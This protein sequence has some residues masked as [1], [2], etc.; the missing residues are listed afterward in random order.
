[1][2]GRNLVA[3]TDEKEK[4][5]QILKE[6]FFDGIDDDNMGIW[7]HD[8]LQKRLPGVEK[9][10]A[11]DYGTEDGEI[12]DENLP[13]TLVEMFG[14]ELF[15]GAFGADLRGK[16]LDKFFELE[17]YSKIFK[18]F[19]GSSNYS[20][21]T[22]KEMKVKFSNDT[23]E[24]SRKYLQSLKDERQKH[25][26]KPGGVFARRFVEQIRL[27]DIFAGIRSEPKSGR[28]E[29]AVP[30][31]DLK[32]LRNFQENMKNQVLEILNGSEENRAIVTLPTGAGKTRI[33]VEAIVKFLND[34]SVDRNILWIAQSQ[35]VCEQAVLCFKQIWEQHGKGETL[36][37]YRAW[38]VND[39]PTSDERGIIVGGVQ[40]LVSRKNELHHISDDGALSAVFIDEAH[41][42]VAD[43]YAKILDN[44]G[45]SM[46]PDGI[47]SNDKIPLIGLTA[48]PERRLD[49]ETKRLLD[50]YGDKRIHP[51]KNSNPP[52]ESNGIMFDENWGNLNFMRKNLEELKFLAH[53]EFIPIDP[54]RTVLK[55]DEKETRDLDG[56]GDL[57]IERIATEPERN[58][59]IKN[60]IIKEAKAGRKILYFGTNVSQSNAMSRILEKNGFSS[61][62]ITGDTRYAARKLYVDTFNDTNSD[63]IQVMCNYNVLSTGFDSP[64]IDTVI[65]AR[66][67]TSIVA[68]QQM[69]GRGLRGEQFGGKPGNHCRIITVK[70]NIR[71]FNDEK[72]E[73]GYTKFERD[74]QEDFTEE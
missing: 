57:W 39:I 20:A 22:I 71:K 55:L 8:Y 42:S 1:M 30:K 6:I 34:N 10:L 12:L 21:S 56:G 59:N 15:E 46:F 3:S 37:I 36:N 45:M 23:K 72:V 18:I 68:Y 53:A 65:I 14:S 54:G 64:Q 26:W 16:I 31:A 43:S 67:T 29:E 62:C 66:P 25:P 49:S 7:L 5:G 40:K 2:S 9:I 19:L 50:M 35:E 24:V 70:D 52:S 4:A 32:E 69:I 41:H 17:E 33:A 27:A 63:G 13:R 11:A 51:S 58:E 44:L 38:G 28:I 60:E 73:L 48:T 61:V 47:K 74:I